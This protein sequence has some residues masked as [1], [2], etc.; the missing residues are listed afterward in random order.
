MKA[1]CGSGGIA[2]HIIDLSTKWWWVVWFMPQLIYPQRKSPCYPLHRKLGGT[3]SWSGCGGEG[4]N[5]YPLP[6]L[7]P[8]I[9]QPITQ[10]YTTELFWLEIFMVM[11]IHFVI[12][13]VLTTC[14]AVVGYQ[15]FRVPCCLCL[16]TAWSSETLVS[17]PIT[18]LCHKTEDRRQHGTLCNILNFS[19]ISLFL[20]LNTLLNNFF[21]KYPYY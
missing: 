11:K 6:E 16:Q 21:F 14:S 9:I 13:W 18:L 20:D 1:Y 2:P 8:P 7:K 15:C 10:R 19:L 3:Q 12:F 17:Y 4:K 5:S